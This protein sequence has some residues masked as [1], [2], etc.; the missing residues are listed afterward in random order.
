[1]ALIPTFTPLLTGAPPSLTAAA[2]SDTARCD[3]HLFLL[4]R[5]TSASSV[6]VTIVTPGTLGTGDAYPDKVIAVGAGTGAGNVVPTEVWIPLIRDYADPA[7]GTA[8]VNYSATTNITRVV[9]AV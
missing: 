9:V 7:T 5:N 6:N 1:M 2:A 3:E 8:A 4:V